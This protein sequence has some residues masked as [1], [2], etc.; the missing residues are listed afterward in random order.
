MAKRFIFA[1]CLFAVLSSAIAQI[2][3]SFPGRSVHL[4]CSTLDPYSADVIL[5]ED[6]C[7]IDQANHM[8][9]MG[10]LCATPVDDSW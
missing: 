3:N 4:C 5:F 2:C 8:E 10:T 1:L 7:N 9:E 6:V